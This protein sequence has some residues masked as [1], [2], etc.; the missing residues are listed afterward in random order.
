MTGSRL[1]L[2]ATAVM[3]TIMPSYAIA[4]RKRAWVKV[5]KM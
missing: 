3:T 5:A 4:W 2:A 1:R